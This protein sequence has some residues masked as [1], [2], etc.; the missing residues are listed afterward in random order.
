MTITLHRPTAQAAADW[1]PCPTWCAGGDDCLGGATTYGITTGRLHQGVLVDEETD[2]LDGSAPQR[3]RLIADRYDDPTGGPGEVR[4]MLNVGAA[5]TY[6][7][8]TV[9]EAATQ[10]VWISPQ[11]AQQLVAAL[12]SVAGQV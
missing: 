8:L 10:S 12:T 5:E 6:E 4:L 9:A 7:H 2:L 11:A 3:L 1:P